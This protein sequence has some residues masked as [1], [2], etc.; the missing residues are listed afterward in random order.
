MNSQN[1]IEMLVLFHN[2]TLQRFL[3]Y[4]KS[5]YAI[6]I[7]VIDKRNFFKSIALS[8]L[9]LFEKID[10]YCSLTFVATENKPQ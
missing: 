4:V 5:E 6:W 7:V 10:S 3:Y 8:K 2:V 1:T 9:A